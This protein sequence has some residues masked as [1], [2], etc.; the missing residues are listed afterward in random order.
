[1]HLFDDQLRH[2]A[3]YIRTSETIYEF[4]DRVSRSEFASVRDMLGAWF[5]RWPTG[6]RKELRTRLMSK[7]RANFDGAVWELY[8]HELHTRLG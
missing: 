2:D 7:D 6:N 8:L 4:V 3:S 1:M 5:E